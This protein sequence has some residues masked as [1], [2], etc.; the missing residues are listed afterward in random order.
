MS[1]IQPSSRFRSSQKSSAQ[2]TENNRI[3]AHPLP[4]ILSEPSQPSFLRKTLGF[5]GISSV[6][7][8]LNPHCQGVLDRRY[9]FGMGTRHER[10]DGALA[11]RFL[12]QG[13]SFQ[14]RTQLVGKADQ[15]E[16]ASEKR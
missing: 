9:A 3:Y 16:E 4:I 5:F 8:I 7:D 2:R 14:E 10:R 15:R 11:A 6:S 1:L 13:R 12:W